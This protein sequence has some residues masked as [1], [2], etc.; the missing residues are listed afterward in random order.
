MDEH[1][2]ALGRRER[3]LLGVLLL[4]AGDVVSVERLIDG[5]WG[6]A[7]PAS[8]K[9]MVHEYVSR[10]RQALGDA[11]RIATRVPGYLAVCC[12]DELDTGRFSRLTAAARTAARAGKHGDALRAYDSALD[13]WRGDAL[14]GAELEGEARV[15]AARLDQERLLVK[16]ERVDSALALGL[17]RDLIPALERHVRD[18]PLRERPRA[19]LMLALYR[20]GRQTEALEHFREARALLVE[21]AGIEPGR[22]LRG[23]ERAILEHDPALE[24]EPPQPRARETPDRA[25]GRRR[26]SARRTILAAVAAATVAAVGAAAWFALADGGTEDVAPIDGNSVAVLDAERGRHTASIA[27]AAGRHRA[28]SRP[29]P[30][31]SGWRTSTRTPCRAST[32]RRAW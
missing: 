11:S 31:R 8:A 26:P 6:E 2:V 19:Q 5:V 10:L 1:V 22:E 18:E 32:L 4:N 13:L 24:L 21:H 12:D 29:G 23:L 27:I 28:P 3:A 9:H 20:A 30:D 16:E 25:E 15:D 7:P 17:H 14:A